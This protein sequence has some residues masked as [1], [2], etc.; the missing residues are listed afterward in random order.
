[1]V[2]DV[3]PPEAAAR[4]SMLTVAEPLALVPPEAAATLCHIDLDV[5]GLGKSSRS[6]Y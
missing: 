4:C 2:L 3:V 6:R 5:V 1:M